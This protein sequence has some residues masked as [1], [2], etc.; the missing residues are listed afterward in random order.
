M[1]TTAISMALAAM[2]T[3]GTASAADS[4]TLQ[5]CIDYALENNI[6]IRQSDIATQ[7]S[8]VDYNSAR[9]NRLPDLSANASQNWSFGRS[10]TIDNTYANTNTASTSFSI[11][12]GV[13]LFA[14]GR[15][16]GNIHKAEL[17]LEAAKSDLERMKDDIRVQV[18]ESFIQI[19]YNQSILEV[20]RNQVSID[21]MQVERLTALAAIG[22]A[23]SA[24]VASQKATL[25]QSRLSVTQA[26]NNLSMS[27]LTLT[28]LLDLPSPEGFDIVQPGADDMEFRMP[29]SPEEIYAQALEIKPS[30]KSEEIRLQQAETSVDIAKG[31]YYPTLSL[32]AG[33]GTGY[34]TSSNR[35]ADSF[36]SQLKNNFGPQIGLSLNI[37]IFSRNS[38][39][40]SVRSA[41][42]NQM[43]Q[44]MQ[45]DNVK[46]QLYKEIQQAYYNAVASKTRYESSQE[47][48]T[49]A[50]ESFE[51]VQAK[52]EGGKASITE[53][54]ES[55]NRLVTA[56]ADV[57]K[58]RYEYL[59]NTALLEFYRNS[60]FEL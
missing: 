27:I 1:K 13:T 10:L 37:P 29:D 59:F 48:E 35:T 8:E 11:G 14:G 16:S 54:N 5:R 9:S 39:R 3:A 12:T 42:L 56:Q 58:Y 19:V 57:I 51:L 55:K 45:L 49:S 23:S 46:K 33:A 20:A 60:S 4:W 50:Q 36:G 52:Y 47:V 21:S 44:E 15:I 26:E 18:A 43:N 31:A 34:Y 53:F 6:Q 28:Q 41:Q 40:N 7:N 17:G 30:I 24:E 22:K 38:N 2:L 32:N 25:A